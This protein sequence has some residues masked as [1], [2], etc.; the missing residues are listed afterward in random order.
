MI[1]GDRGC[2]AGVVFETVCTR[3]DIDKRRLLD[4]LAGIARFQVGERAVACAQNLSRPGENATTLDPSHSRPDPQPSVCRL[5]GALHF[6]GPGHIDLGQEL[7]SGWVNR[8]ECAT[9]EGV[10]MGPSA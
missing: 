9:A 3:V 2:L 6:F 7:A 5:D 10:G 1:T 8:C 4:R